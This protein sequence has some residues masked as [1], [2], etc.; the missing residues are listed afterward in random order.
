MSNPFEKLAALRDRLPPGPSTTTPVGKPAPSPLDG[1]IVVRHERKGRGGRTVTVVQG[2]ALQG[3]ALAEF[4]R[5]MK[6]A[7]GCGAT[8]EDAD[9]V[10]QGELVER[11]ASWLE[12]QG[13]RRV[14]RATA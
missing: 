12:K 11:V 9:V 3:D 6:K 1:K 5:G 8:I 7:L 10:L 13:A 14:V 4:A 2:V